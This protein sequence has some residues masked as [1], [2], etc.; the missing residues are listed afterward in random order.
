LKQEKMVDAGKK[1]KSDFEEVCNGAAAETTGMVM[2]SGDVAV[3]AER[4]PTVGL[5]Q[6]RRTAVHEVSP[7]NV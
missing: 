1:T 5:N 2:L 7:E 4:V 6:R 3:P